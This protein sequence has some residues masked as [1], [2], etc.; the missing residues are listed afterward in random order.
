MDGIDS[1]DGQRISAGA[2]MAEIALTFWN[3]GVQLSTIAIAN[4][5]LPPDLMEALLFGN[6]G[7]TCPREKTG[8]TPTAEAPVVRQGNG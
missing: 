7:R 2:G 5:R 4:G 3:V 8:C 1:A 6:S